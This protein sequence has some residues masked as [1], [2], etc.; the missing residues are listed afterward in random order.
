[1]TSFGQQ[2]RFGRLLLDH[3]RAAGLT[4]AELARRSGTSVRAIGDLERERSLAPQRATVDALAT[5]LGLPPDATAALHR[6]AAAPDGLPAPPTD[7]TGR[8]PEL[9]RLRALAWAAVSGSAGT[10]TIAAV[11]GQPGLGKTCLALRAARDSAGRFP[12][13]VFHLDLLGAHG[14]GLPVPDALS[15]LLRACGVAESQV[16]AD[17]DAR[18]A[19]YRSLTHDRRMLLILDNAADEAQI[20]PLLPGSAHSMVLVTSRRLLPGLETSARILLDVLPP[21][22][23]V[24]L[25]GR[26]AGPGRIAAEATAAAD[27]ARL[28]GGL[29]LAL[30]I[31]GNRLRRSTGPGAVG[32]LAG[33][34]RYEEHRLDLLG[35]GDQ[36][37]R[38]VLALAYR[39]LDPAARRLFRLLALVPGTEFGAPAAAALA[40]AETAGDLLEE[41]VDASMLEPAGTA[42]RYRFHDLIRLFA[43]EALHD[44]E[45]AAARDA[46]ESRMIHDLIGRATA[47]GLRFH[48]DGDGSGPS[49]ETATA[50]LDADFAL[51]SEA[52][53][54][55]A[56]RGMHRPVLDLA[57]AMH[58]FSDYRRYD[59]GWW[60]ELF[61]LGLAAARALGSRPE[62][63][64]QLNYLSWACGYYAGRPADAVRYA[65]EAL[66][67]A[68]T[69]GN[70]TEAA[71][72]R[73]YLAAAHLRGGDPERARPAYLAAAAAM[74]EVGD[75]IGEDQASRHHGVTLRLTGDPA[76][77]AK[78][79]RSVL[80][81]FRDRARHPD[82]FQRA[83]GMNAT[84]TE[85]GHDL[86]ALGRWAE[87]AG[88]YRAALTWL[89][90][91]GDPWHEAQILA[92]LGAALDELGDPEAPGVL[93]RAADRFAEAN[94]PR[95]RAEVLDRLRPAR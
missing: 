1:M 89:P 86:A 48:P 92:G 30:R 61:G 13:G 12:D 40:G 4:Q 35:A 29:P 59:P 34:M 25:L 17:A 42:F 85:L 23:A 31:A 39:R 94:D 27:L 87:A 60:A 16:P 68:G 56:A 72:A 45:P 51:W 43:T 52:A 10:V 20:R 38:A 3:R 90:A 83:T 7:F 11:S 19:L 65:T 32:E 77:A 41:L 8:G 58:W 36:Q 63:V 50:W 2:Q 79:H 18:G 5:A 91:L 80:A 53:R 22:N 46:A 84:L 93:R 66:A 78:T 75:A 14:A 67:L 88:A 6:A 44:D 71:W 70:R 21:E 49:W 76:G 57:E 55:A 81:R 9:A 24:R 73:V 74:A 69:L 62:E 82:E 64:A 95:G 54:R 28:C 33:L 47:A 37:V 26:T 15:R